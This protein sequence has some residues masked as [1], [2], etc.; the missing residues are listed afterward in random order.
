MLVNPLYRIRKIEE[1]EDVQE[2]ANQKRIAAEKHEI[3]WAA[4]HHRRR[5]DMLDSFL[6]LILPDSVGQRK[7]NESRV[8]R[9]LCSLLDAAYELAG[10]EKDT[11]AHA[12]EQAAALRVLQLYKL[13]Q[14]AMYVP[15]TCYSLTPAAPTLVSRLPTDV[16]KKCLN[17]SYGFELFEQKE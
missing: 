15:S 9:E 6:G 10:A 3:N 13:C 16:W 5:V 17:Y 12:T 8:R 11:L 14:P 2:Q 4:R 7:A 1:V